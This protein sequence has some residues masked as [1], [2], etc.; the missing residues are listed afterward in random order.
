MKC[1]KQSHAR[2]HQAERGQS[3]CLVRHRVDLLEHAL[4]AARADERVQPLDHQH[5]RDCNQQ[6]RH[7]QAFDVAL[8]KRP[9]QISGSAL[10]LFA[11]SQPLD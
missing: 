11:T 6:F 4:V 1:V 10:P 5:Q 2:N 7:E 3:D 9:E 8:V